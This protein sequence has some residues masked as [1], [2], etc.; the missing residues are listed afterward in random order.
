MSFFLNLQAKSIVKKIIQSHRNDIQE[1]IKNNVKYNDIIFS[2]LQSNSETFYSA[3]EETIDPETCK[4][5]YQSKRVKLHDAC[6]GLLFNELEK[7][8]EGQA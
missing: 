4:I 6:I 5:L 1:K 8:E 2:L 7:I 3:N